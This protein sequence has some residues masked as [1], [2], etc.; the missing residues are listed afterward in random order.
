M[1]KVEF[2]ANGQS[3]LPWALR[4]EGG[5][6]IRLSRAAE[7]AV[8]QRHGNVKENMFVKR[9]WRR[10]LQAYVGPGHGR[11]RAST[12]TRFARDSPARRALTGTR[13]ARDSAHADGHSARRAI[14]LV[15]HDGHPARRAFRLVRHDGHPAQRACGLVRH[16]GHPARR[17]IGLVQHDGH[18]ARRAIGLV[19]PVSGMGVMDRQFSRASIPMSGDR[20]AMVRVRHGRHGSPVFPRSDTDAWGSGRAGRG[21]A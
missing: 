16:D 11:R 4:V 15:R 2:K 17:A 10:R 21:S 7:R 3:S 19:R 12:G 5:P 14:G 1:D 8:M 13:A 18:P 9:G 6:T 20:C